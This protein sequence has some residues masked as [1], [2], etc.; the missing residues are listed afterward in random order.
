MTYFHVLMKYSFTKSERQSM[1]LNSHLNLSHALGRS[2]ME[3]PK[4]KKALGYQTVE[5]KR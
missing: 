5:R 1:R 3:R 4:T 2:M